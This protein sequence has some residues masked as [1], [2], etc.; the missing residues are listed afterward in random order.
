MCQSCSVKYRGSIGYFRVVLVQ[1][2]FNVADDCLQK[3]CNSYQFDHLRAGNGE[4]KFLPFSSR[5]RL[6]SNLRVTD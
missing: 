1:R 6:R 4:Y 2:V 5:T 3:L